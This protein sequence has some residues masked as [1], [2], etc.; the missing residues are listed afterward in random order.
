MEIRSEEKRPMYEEFF[1]LFIKCKRQVVLTG[2]GVSTLSGIKDF[3]SSDGLY[4]KEFGH[5]RVEDIL[6]ID[7]FKAHPDV[8]YSW[9]K[10]NWYNID[11]ARPNIIH[12]SL[13][14]AE[15]KGYISEGIFTQNIDFLHER[16]GSKRVYPLHGTLQ[17]GYCMNCHSYHEYDEISKIVHEDKIPLCSCG[18]V[19]KPD[20]VFYG[21]P[22][23]SSILSRAESAFT[24][25]D[26]AIV[27]GTS[28]VVNPAATLP[29][30]SARKGKKIVIVNRDDT[31]LDNYATL[32]YRD[33]KSFFEAFSAFIKSI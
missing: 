25:A 32:R 3:R 30:L 21:E 20:I 1:D 17:R 29:F 10:D 15:E 9:A 31:Y 4:S 11:E 7:F 28:L 24:N 22:L 5:M 16:V 19:I 18:G 12:E 27:L 23:D 8:F 14:E 2:A 6:D 33:L 26:L 13:K